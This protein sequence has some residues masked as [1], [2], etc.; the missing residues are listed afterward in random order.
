MSGRNP[1]SKGRRSELIGTKD[2]LISGVI[3]RLDEL[4]ANT[5][6]ELMLKKSTAGN[7]DL[8]KELQ[9]P[10]L[11][12]FRMPETMFNTD[13]ERDIDAKY[14]LT[15]LWLALQIR[16]R[17]VDDRFKLIKVNLIIDEL[18]QVE[19]TQMFLSKIFRC[20]T[21]WRFYVRRSRY[22]LRVD[23]EVPCST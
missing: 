9:R 3:D 5:Y 13:G 8:V 15:K 2:H 12:I 11:I 14:W 6:M 7:I 20:F 19:Q 21:S 1:R 18:Y 22:C 23:S 4:K 10:Q 16:E 17:S